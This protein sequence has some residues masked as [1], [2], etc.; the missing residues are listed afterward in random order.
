MRDRQNRGLDATGGIL[1]DTTL[2]R[3]AAGLPT[4]FPVPHFPTELGAGVIAFDSGFASAELL[5]DLTRFAVSALTVHRAE[6]LQY[7][8]NQGQPELRG[9]IAGYMNEDGCALTPD[10]IIVTN[11]A[12][13]GIELV[14]KLTLD[15]GDAVVVTAPTYF[16]AIPIFRSFGVE[17]IEVPQD[18]DGLCVAKLRETLDARAAAGARPPKLIYN[19]SDFH[20]PTGLSMSLARRVALVALAEERGIRI[21][22]DN[23]YRRV[24]FTGG[25]LPTLKA[26]DR[27]GTVIHAGTFSKLVAPGLR[28]GWLAAEPD[29]IARLI[30]L[31]ADGGSSA[32]LQRI[33][34]EFCSSQDFPVHVR[35]VE[36]VYAEHRDCMIAALK[37]ELP[38]VSFTV[39]E[40]G[41]Y[42]WVKLPP[43][44]DGDA[45]AK[46]AAE[47]GVNIIPGTKFFALDNDYPSNR[48]TARNH[49]RLS[50]SFATLEE[51]DE[52]I[53]RLADALREVGSS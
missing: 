42:I 7:S 46:R 25:S 27:T 45:V 26:L 18:K 19:V 35:R 52:G 14:C 33:V 39:P 10:N 11:G 15:D 16:S 37:R 40:G 3:R 38:D 49:I 43:H 41:Y 6:T 53:V 20:N 8:A 51:I 1:T 28:I 12:K 50:Y 24:R 2:A 44:V 34:Y 36:K 47:R 22:E 23:P 5:P 30:A 29:V 48:S 32:F 13:H 4:T 9:W 17:L 31:K 21:I